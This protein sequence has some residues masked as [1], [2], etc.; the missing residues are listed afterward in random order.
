MGL[1]SQVRGVGETVV[2]PVV[3][4]FTNFEKFY[5]LFKLFSSFSKLIAVS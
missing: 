1:R 2:R 3:R 4:L 5:Y